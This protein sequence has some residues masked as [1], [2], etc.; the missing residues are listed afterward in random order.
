MP[1]SPATTTTAEGPRADETKPEELLQAGLDSSVI[2]LMHDDV[3]GEVRQVIH[4]QRKS[5]SLV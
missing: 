4:T 5:F 1:Q 2:E 3:D